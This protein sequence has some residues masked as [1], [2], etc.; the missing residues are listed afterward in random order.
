[1]IPIREKPKGIN[2]LVSIKAVSNNED[3]SSNVLSFNNAHE[4]HSATKEI[5]Y[6]EMV[7]AHNN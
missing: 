7:S 4:K 2:Y 6:S 5:L 1:M 3:Y